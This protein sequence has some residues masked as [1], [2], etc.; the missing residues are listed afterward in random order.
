MVCQQR[1]ARCCSHCVKPSFYFPKEKGTSSKLVSRMCFLLLDIIGSHSDSN[2]RLWANGNSKYFSGVSSECCSLDGGQ[3]HHSL[4]H[5][6]H[7]NRLGLPVTW[8][9]T[10][11]PDVRRFLY[12]FQQ[13]FL[14]SPSVGCMIARIESRRRRSV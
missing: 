1:L 2:A 11:V 5:S 9:P 4:D 7:R 8:N 10:G 12:E 6:N 14:S 13:T 3:R